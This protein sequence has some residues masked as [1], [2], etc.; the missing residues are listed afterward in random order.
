[1]LGKSLSAVDFNSLL[2]AQVESHGIPVAGTLDLAPALDGPGAPFQSHLERY[3]LWLSQGH[4][5]AMT[6][7]ERGRDRRAD[8]RLVFAEAQSILC[9]AIPYSTRSPAA[10][11]AERGVRYARYLRG[12]DYHERIAELLEQVMNSTRLALSEQGDP[13]A[14][15]LRWKVCVDTS[16]LLERSWA[17]LAGL[18]WIG[19]NTL[20]IHPRLGSYLFL[21]EVLINRKTGSLPRP[22]PDLCGH[23]ERCLQACPT[24][25]IAP[26]RVVQSR[27]CVSY[28]TLEKRGEW[29]A[30]AEVLR[31]VGSWVAGCDVCQ[32]VCP[33]NLKPMRAESSQ[34]EPLEP[35]LVTQW[36]RLLEETEEEYRSRVA[37]SALSR[38]KA[39]QFSRNL[40][41]AFL[42]QL[43]AEESWDAT[44]L[45]PVVEARLE[46]ESV[47][48]ERETWARCLSHLRARAARL[49]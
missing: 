28:L 35:A 5:G 48:S 34:P 8:P 19:K 16:A 49:P 15:E 43:E 27:K 24:G 17:A 23:C 12:Q 14:A 41:N 26:S 10:E 13:R 7:L 9:V 4:A 3:D 18:G 29:E 44:S 20:L 31:H 36:K 46:R 39:A 25:A 45:I 42:N 1:M 2:L 47:V 21:A 40:A 38:V 22:M 33:F 30:P 11:S 32:E 37:H 6:Y